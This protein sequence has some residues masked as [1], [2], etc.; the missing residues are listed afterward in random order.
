MASSVFGHLCKS[1][2]EQVSKKIQW[3]ENHLPSNSSSGLF[4]HFPNLNLFITYLYSSKSL[5]KV[6]KEAIGRI[7]RPLI[8]N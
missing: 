7:F 1:D 4:H 5:K 3:S 6:F 2:S 8:M